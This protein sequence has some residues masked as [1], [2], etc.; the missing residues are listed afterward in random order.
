MKRRQQKWERKEQN[1]PGALAHDTA[2]WRGGREADTWGGFC[3]RT[4]RTR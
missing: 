2:A 3:D 1:E 4:D